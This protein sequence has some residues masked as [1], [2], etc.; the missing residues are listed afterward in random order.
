MLLRSAYLMVTTVLSI[1]RLLSTGDRAK[2]I[3]ILVLRHQLTVLRRKVNMPVFTREDRFLLAGLFACLP[4]GAR[5][6]LMLLVRPDT[7]LRWHRDLLRRR[8]AAASAHRRP[9]RPRTVRPIR[10]LVLRP[11]R[12]KLLVGLPAYP[13]RTGRT[14]HQ[15]RRL[16]GL[17][18]PQSPRH[19]PLSRTGATRGLTWPD[20]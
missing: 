1:L 4:M 3:E 9:G 7:I 5:R 11:A 18:D 6:S 12:E 19:R 2:D 16:D 17:G 14:R 8:H 15:G 10:V 13:R 20:D